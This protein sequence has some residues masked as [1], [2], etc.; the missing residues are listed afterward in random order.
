MYAGVP[1]FP[2]GSSRLLFN[3][4]PIAATSCGIACLPL[5]PGLHYI[6]FDSVQEL[7]EDVA[8][9][10]D[11]IARLNSMQLVAHGQCDTGFDW[12]ERD[13]TLRNAI[14]QA[15]NQQCALT[16]GGQHYDRAV[17]C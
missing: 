5:T 17:G 13:R 8:A 4:A 12:S 1:P 2:R 9:V 6:L 15:V 16:Q 7:A 3:Q 11:D 14:L 10:I